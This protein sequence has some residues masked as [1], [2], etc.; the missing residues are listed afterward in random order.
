MDIKDFRKFINESPIKEKLNNLKLVL[1]YP[2][3]DSK[4]ELVGIQ[5][6]YK[7]IYDQVISWNHYEILPEYLRNS[8]IHF[9]SLKSN[10][11][12]LTTFFSE[13][14]KNQ[15]DNKWNQ[16]IQL[17]SNVKTSN[18]S[19]VFL[20]D[21]PETDF[22]IKTNN[23]S[24]NY[25]QGII[26]YFVKGNINMNNG[27]DYITG[28]LY[29]YEFKNQTESE[30]LH[31]RNNEK[32]SLN[33]IREKYN[34]YIVEAEQ[35]LNGYILDAKE[36]LINHFD[37]V[38]KLKEESNKQFKDWF[39]Q[40]KFDFEKFQEESYKKIYDLEDLY[41]YRLK[42]EAP[43]DYWKK[44]AKLLK[45]EGRSFLFCLIGVSLV[46]STFLFVL[47][48]SLGNGFFDE[49]FKN[50]LIGIKWS[51]ILV[52]IV[53]LLAFTIKILSKMTFS[54]FH[55]SRDAEEREQLTH[56]YL[57]LKKDTTIEPEERQL[58]LQSLFSRADTG[59]LKDDSSPTM[60]T[61]S[62]IEKFSG[63]R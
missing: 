5:S 42:L 22:L 7:F 14:N 8:K 25:L 46:A 36:N 28:V 29:A 3:L 45:S 43:A 56:F 40:E 59:L 30:I 18:G 10:L 53:S 55:L 54:S 16:Y 6:I 1:N 31:R 47:L 63:G 44:R 15:F 37:T 26:D 39:N 11:I 12:S 23:K 57:A 50:T 58:I 19:F 38:E 35:Q 49:A 60:P 17:I 21:L 32:I 4:F 2:H 33:Q 27:S 62:I 41:R 13:D 52:T 20:C 9:E 34:N 61:T 48:I 51:I 24:P